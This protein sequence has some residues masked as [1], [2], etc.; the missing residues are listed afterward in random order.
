MINSTH[1][2]YDL[3]NDQAVT[4]D[5]ASNFCGGNPSSSNVA[6]VSSFSE[7]G[8]APGQMERG[9]VEQTTTRFV[10]GTHRLGV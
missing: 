2:F 1:S 6:G 5:E 7:G 3:A 9:K 8:N 4:S 10:Q